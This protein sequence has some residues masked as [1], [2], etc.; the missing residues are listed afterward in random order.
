MR[1]ILCLLKLQTEQWQRKGQEDHVHM[2]LNACQELTYAV[3]R[4]LRQQG[5]AQSCNR[6]PCRMLVRKHD[7]ACSRIG[8]HTT[9]H[10]IELWKPSCCT[11]PPKTACLKVFEENLHILLIDR[12][13]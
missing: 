5:S 1:G 12:R 10:S 4:I 13:T 3:R 6:Q 9:P 11:P 8:G 7:V 2:Q